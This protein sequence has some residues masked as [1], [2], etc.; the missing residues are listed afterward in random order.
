LAKLGNVP[1]VVAG[2]NRQVE[3]FVDGKWIKLEE[4]P[5][6]QYSYYAYSVVTFKNQ[7]YYFGGKLDSLDTELVITYDGAGRP[8]FGPNRG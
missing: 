2:Y 1:I 4:F 8:Q 3:Q 5:F 7:L 6:C